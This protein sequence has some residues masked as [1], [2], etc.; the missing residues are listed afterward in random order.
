MSI[1]PSGR[2]L[3]TDDCSA[4]IVIN[5]E[6]HR[7]NRSGPREYVYNYKRGTGP[8][9][10]SYYYE[11]DYV[12]K[13]HGH[14][15]SKFERSKLYDLVIANRYAI[16][17]ESNRGIPGSQCTLIG[18]G[19]EEGDCVEIGSVRCRTTFNS[20]NS[21]SFTVPMLSAS[22]KHHARLVSDNG[23]IGLGNFTIDPM[24]FCANLSRIDLA[25]GEKQALVICT[26]FP[27][28]EGGIAIDVTTTIP[29]SVIMRDIFIPAGARSATAVVRGGISGSGMLYL[30][31]GGFEELRIPVEVIDANCRDDQKSESDC[32][33]SDDNSL[34]M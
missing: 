15:R 11:L 16:G 8:H 4:R 31:A 18:R 32:E 12:E 24:N 26:D 10:A 13:Q 21:L 28:P 7:M 22:G 27:A 3:V 5:G 17:F 23:D 6:V 2:E 29:D 25:S 9:K 33:F 20:Q 14:A 1:A 19:F 30:T 34:A